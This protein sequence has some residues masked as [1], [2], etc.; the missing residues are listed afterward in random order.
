MTS[1]AMLTDLSEC[2]SAWL[3]RY[4]R[5][6]EV[7]SSNLVTPT[8]FKILSVNCLR[9]TDFLFSHNVLTLRQL[10]VLRSIPWL[11]AE[12]AFSADFELVPPSSGACSPFVV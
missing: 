9:L 11:R 10:R 12:K 8:I 2:S 3:E 1:S 4:V 6:V 5:D 7:A